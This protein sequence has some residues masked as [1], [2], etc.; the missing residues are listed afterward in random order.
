MQPTT[1]QG[2]SVL[3]HLGNDIPHVPPSGVSLPRST[4]R[5]PVRVLPQVHRTSHPKVPVLGRQGEK[6][7]R[8]RSSLAWTTLGL[9]MGQKEMWGKAVARPPSPGT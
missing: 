2:M 4:T 9:M 8:V 1:T 6:V 3:S 7:G 5:S